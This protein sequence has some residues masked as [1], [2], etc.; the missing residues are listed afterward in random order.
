M[1]PA[2]LSVRLARSW[3]PAEI[4]AEASCTV[5]A[6]S[7]SWRAMVFSRS[8][9]RLVEPFSRSDEHTSE[10]PSL[11]RH[12]HAVFCLKKEYLRTDTS[13]PSFHLALFTLHLY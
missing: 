12:S 13:S 5:R 2:W 10:L 9:M 7:A 1:L 3:L 8:P 4:S 6:A 11:M